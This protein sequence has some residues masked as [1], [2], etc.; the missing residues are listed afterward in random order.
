MTLLSGGVGGARLARGF[1]RLAG[2]QTTVV[3]NVGDDAITHSLAVSPDIDTVLYTLAGMEGPQ[4]WGR[5]QDTFTTNSELGRFGLDNTFK[6]GDKDLALK[7]A[8]TDA[9]ASGDDLSTF[10]DSIRKSLDIDTRVLPVSNDTIRTRIR[11]EDDDWISFQEYFV[12][13]RHSDR[14]LEVRYEGAADADPA[15]GVVDAIESAQLL[16]I[17]PS[18]PPLSIWPIL[19]VPGVRKAVERHPKTI[20]VSPLVGGKAVKGPVVELMASL[21]LPPGSRGVVAAYEGLIHRLV[22]N[23]EDLEWW[24]DHGDVE[25]TGAQTL[26]KDPEA[27]RLL[28]ETLS[29]F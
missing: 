24:A 14:V 15:P 9:L 6:L 4:G 20:A 17:G 18:N 8:R 22:V 27:A 21:G 28:A 13:R 2:A 19:E 11:T 29:G 16:V 7:I 3:V 25:L 23:N 5:S 1:E 26:I 12:R 10:T